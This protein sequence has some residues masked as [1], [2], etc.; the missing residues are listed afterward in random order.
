MSTE[1]SC[2]KATFIIYDEQCEGVYVCIA[3][4]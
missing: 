2:L 1:N 4:I 3:H